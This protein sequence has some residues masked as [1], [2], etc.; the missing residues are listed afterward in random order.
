MFKKLYGIIEVLVRINDHTIDS[1]L[2]DI[3]DDLLDVSDTFGDRMQIDGIIID[4]RDIAKTVDDS[5]RER[6][7]SGRNDQADSRRTWAIAFGL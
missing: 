6:D 1:C 5:T 4:L 3:I 7:R 2:D